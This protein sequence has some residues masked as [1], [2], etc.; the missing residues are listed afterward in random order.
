LKDRFERN[1]SVVLNAED[2]DRAT[3]RFVQLFPAVSSILVAQ[4]YLLID[5]FVVPAARCCGAGIRLLQTATEA[6]HKL[7]EALGWKRDDKF[8]VYGLPL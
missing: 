5:L 7:Y 3:I 1:E 2:R 4:I 8:Y 6:A